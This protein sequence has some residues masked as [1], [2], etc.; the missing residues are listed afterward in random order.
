[1]KILVIGGGGREHVLA[2]KLAQSPRVQT[3]YAWPDNGGLDEIA[4][5]APLEKGAGAAQLADFAKKQGIDLTVVGPEALLCEGIVDLFEEKGLRIFGPNKK[6]AQIEGSKFWAKDLMKKYGVPTAEYEKFDIFDT[7]LASVKNKNRFPVVIKA[8][9]LAAGKGVTVAQN[10]EEAEA[11]LRENFLEGKFG[12]AGKRVIVEECLT[13]QEASLIAFV[14]GKT[15]LPML[16][17]QDH[18][19]LLDGDKGPNTGGMGAICPTPL[20]DEKMQAEILEKVFQPMLKGFQSEGIQFK[21]VLYAGL[22]IEEAGPKVLEFNC[23]FGDPE[24]Q[25]ILP[26]MQTDLSELLE[27]TIDGKLEGVHIQW[28]EGKTCVTVVLAS[29]GYPGGYKKG[30]PIEGL[31]EFDSDSQ[32]VI[33]F[34]AGTARD[35]NMVVT[36]GGRVLGVTAVGQSAQDARE[37]AYQAVE[38]IHF[39]AVQYRKDI[40]R[41]AL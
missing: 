10:L 2:W 21:G 12:D 25:A 28:K 23:R 20:V 40:G 11:A 39:D 3:L 27:A 26:L 18:K 17:A 14:D 13:G 4:I 16:P 41:K 19:P 36:S 6:A 1:M 33:I 22:M 8:D 30:V 37:K 31:D 34:H 5:A 24:A 7:A 9:G 32:D 38:K 29:G 35:R 15:V